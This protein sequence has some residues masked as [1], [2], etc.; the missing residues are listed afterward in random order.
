MLAVV[1]SNED[2]ILNRLNCMKLSHKRWT[3]KQEQINIETALK[4][5]FSSIMFNRQIKYPIY[6]EM[7]KSIKS[8]IESLKNLKKTS[9]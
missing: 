5:I 9:N 7:K 8:D 6:E 2:N 3:K 4:D 1:S